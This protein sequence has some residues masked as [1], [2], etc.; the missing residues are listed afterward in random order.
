MHP[1]VATTD[2]APPAPSS[3]RPRTQTRWTEFALALGGFAIGTS[4]FS[5]MGLLPDVARELHVSVPQ[6]GHLIS[7]YALGVMVGA[8]VLAVACARLPRHLALLGL[9][10]ALALG[11]IASALAPSYESL[12]V[13]RF[14]SGFPHGTFFGMAALVVADLAGPAARARAVGRLMLGLTIACV[15]GSPLATGIGQYA[16]WR[17]AY[18]FIGG[19]AASAWLLT[20]LN[21]PRAA[22]VAG[23]SPLRELGALRRV[24]VWLTLGVGSV[25]FGGLFAV[26]TYITPT[27]TELA[28]LRV[29]LVPF[30]LA[31]VGLGMVVGNLVGASFADRSLPK[32]IVAALLWN[33]LTLVSFWLTARNPWAA[34][35]SAFALGMG[36]ALVPGLQTRLMDV[37]A[38]AQTLAASLNHSAFNLANALGA[39]FGGLVISA[40]FGWNA[41]GVV[42]AAMAIGGLTFFAVSMGL[43]RRSAAVAQRNAFTM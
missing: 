26:Y 28:G 27:M 38:D 36:F 43:E 7:A 3:A 23:A 35:L 39:W 18:L 32:T 4:E 14:L 10:A 13:L 19:I 37:A 41:T 21:I 2:T 11:N 6:A 20:L 17:T 1:P 8:P 5:I 42:G 22:A 30:V 9:M 12:M 15:V 16:S 34:S 33:V 40:G 24:Q 25:G 31:G 29:G